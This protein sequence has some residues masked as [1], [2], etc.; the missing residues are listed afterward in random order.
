MLVVVVICLAIGIVIIGKIIEANDSNN[1]TNE[2]QKDYNSSNITTNNTSNIDVKKI[3]DTLEKDLKLT[4]NLNDLDEEDDIF[5]D[6]EE[7][8]EFECE[9][10]FKK[11]SEEEYE[12]YDG[13]CE[14][15]FYDAHLDDEGKF[16]D[17]EIY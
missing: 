10:C 4:D 8:L 2:V 3:I 5:G 6:N 14:D 15:C 11:I 7:N 17:E 13:M 16:H 12:L 9:V 1:N